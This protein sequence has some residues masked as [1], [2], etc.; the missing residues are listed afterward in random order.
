[1]KLCPDCFTDISCPSCHGSGKPVRSLLG[2][3][4][5]GQLRFGDYCSACG[6]SLKPL[7]TDRCSTCLGTGKELFHQ[8]TRRFQ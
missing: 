1:M 8:C 4:H 6:T 3:Y 2:T 5:C 7:L